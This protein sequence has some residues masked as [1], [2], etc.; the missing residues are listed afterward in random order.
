ME[1]N[2]SEELKNLLIITV[3]IILITIGLY[4]LTEKVL[5]KDEAEV[6]EEKINYKEILVGNL[7]DQPID[8]YY[9]IAYDKTSDNYYKYEN[10]YNK[11]LEKED[12]LSIYQI[13]LGNGFNKKFLSDEDN[14]KPKNI[15]DI[16]IK[17]VGLFLIKKGKISK[18]YQ[19]YETIDKAFK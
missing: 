9:V 14:S 3:I 6:I 4:Y 13:N 11:Y 10:L 1:T 2:T 8:E 16:K 17:D 7:F 5:K 19:T 18:Y 15:E 12:S